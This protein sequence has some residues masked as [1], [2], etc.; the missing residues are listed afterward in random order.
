MSAT[1]YCYDRDTPP[2][3]WAGKYDPLLRFGGD[4]FE[5]INEL[6]NLVTGKFKIVLK[7][8]NIQDNLYINGKPCLV[9]KRKFESITTY[10]NVK[11]LKGVDYGSG[12]SNSYPHISFKGGSC[13]VEVITNGFPHFELDTYKM[14]IEILHLNKL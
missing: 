11:L 12:G 1:T 13:V 14:K 6:R 3:T 8:S 7:L 2:Y 5:L 10:K 4:K 9:R